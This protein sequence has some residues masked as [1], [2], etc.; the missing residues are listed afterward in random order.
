M[1]N[2]SNIMNGLCS[3][4]KNYA[5]SPAYTMLA[6]VVTYPKTVYMLK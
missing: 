4:G 5:G 1:L 3:S 6:I 2:I